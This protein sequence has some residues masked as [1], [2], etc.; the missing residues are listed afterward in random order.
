[1]DNRKWIVT[2]ISV[3]IVGSLLL[4]G[5][6]TAQSTDPIGDT[7][8][9][10][11]YNYTTGFVLTED[12][13]VDGDD[14]PIYP[15]GEI[16]LNTSETSTG[17]DLAYWNDSKV[18][19]GKGDFAAIAR[20]QPEDVGGGSDYFE[21][22]EF[23]GNFRSFTIRW[24]SD[25][26]V[27]GYTDVSSP[28]NLGVTWDNETEQYAKIEW[29]ESQSE[30]S[31]TVW[32]TTESEP[33]PQH[34]ESYSYSFD[35]YAGFSV[36]SGTNNEFYA[37]EFGVGTDYP[38]DLDNATIT[39][40]VTD[41]RGNPIGDATVRVSNA[42]R[43]IEKTTNAD[44]TY[45]VSVNGGS[46][47]VSVTADGYLGERRNLSLSYGEARTVDFK[48][49]EQS[50]AIRFDA[51]G[52]MEHGERR[53]YSVAG[54]VDGE[55]RDITENVSVISDSPSIVVIDTTRT[56]LIATSNKSVSGTANITVVWDRPDMNETLRVEEGIVVA[57]LTVD[58]LDI[59]PPTQ[60]FAAVIGGGTDQNPADKSYLAIFLATALASAV[61]LIATVTAG[62][63]IMPVVLFAAM[64]VGLVEIQVVIAATLVCIFLGLNIG[65]N[66]D[67][68][69]R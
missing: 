65:Q 53:N 13:W 50:S 35:G 63:A 25:N 66:I 49:E 41:T 33:A 23:S 47:N 8:G 12:S 55:F 57:N 18:S 4:G 36:S 29:D 5:V 20:V 11:T 39:G 22:A 46:W 10:Y 43:S 69:V 24:D 15:G 14:D 21:I 2:A 62:L 61:S 52:F 59:L 56:R 1:M 45:A 31:F 32:N 6:A 44:G 60:K 58:N 3:C 7:V 67:Y 16:V 28:T 37:D 42:T 48:L 54:K 68:G 19:V 26:T 17:G 51:P 40:T 34:S 30:V 64:V 27:Y 38:L 9:D